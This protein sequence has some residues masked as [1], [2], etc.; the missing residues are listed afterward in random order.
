MVALLAENEGIRNDK[1]KYDRTVEHWVKRRNKVATQLT[2]DQKRIQGES[3]YICTN[4]V[5]DLT[6]THP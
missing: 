4:H 5:T 3:W 6:S 1:E 2:Q